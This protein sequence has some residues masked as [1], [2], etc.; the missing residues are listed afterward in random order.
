M[1][2]NLD[3]LFISSNMILSTENAA[4]APN[5]VQ[6]LVPFKERERIDAYKSPKG[7]FGVLFN[8][9][10]TWKQKNNTLK[11]LVT[12]AK[13]FDQAEV[14]P[15][16]L[17]TAGS[18]ELQ[19]YLDRS[20]SV[21]GSFVN[22]DPTQ[23][24]MGGTLMNQGVDAATLAS[25]AAGA[26]T[27]A[28]EAK[29]FCNLLP[30]NFFWKMDE[31]LKATHVKAAM[32]HAE[33]IAAMTL[34]VTAKATPI[35][36][37]FVFADDTM[38][39]LTFIDPLDDHNFVESYTKFIQNIFQKLLK[40]LARIQ[41]NKTDQN[42][43]EE[44]KK[45]FKQ[46]VEQTFGLLEH[47]DFSVFNVSGEVTLNAIMKL[48]ANELS[49][50]NFFRDYYQSGDIN[51]LL[52]KIQQKQVNLFLNK[53]QALQQYVEGLNEPEEFSTEQFAF[54]QLFFEQNFYLSSSHATKMMRIMSECEE[55]IKKFQKMATGFATAKLFPNTSAVSLFQK[56]MM[57]VLIC[58]SEEKIVESL[59][60]CFEGKSPSLK[61][62]YN[63]LPL[64]S[65]ALMY[66]I[67]KG[68]GW[69]DLKA[70][71]VL[72]QEVLDQLKTLITL[73]CSGG[74]T[75]TQIHYVLNLLKLVCPN[76]TWQ[77]YNNLVSQISN[78]RFRFKKENDGNSYMEEDYVAVLLQ[79][80]IDEIEDLF[81]M[82]T[83]L[84]QSQ[85]KKN[86]K[87]P[88]VDTLKSEL[89]KLKTTVDTISA[90]KTVESKDEK[91]D[92]KGWSTTKWGVVI[93]VILFG[94]ALGG[95]AIWFLMNPKSQEP[96]VE[97][98]PNLTT[99]GA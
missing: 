85:E 50:K 14:G 31:V 30:N 3:M 71:N 26:I 42:D 11:A 78:E 63:A 41:K 74:G 72:K 27:V 22:S 43:D 40:D 80:E 96:G 5:K 53:S 9:I 93:G 39:D 45:M 7:C 65:Q 75:L 76:K 77:E 99:A 58:E 23:M 16:K 97:V 98:D 12:C 60:A 24:K 73:I 21:C 56:R 10:N 84:K 57:K 25:G 70:E 48:Y 62:L 6:T 8:Q 88:Q 82:A 92:E 15:T 38:I 36:I 1:L 64:F 20:H 51:A 87:N 32:G 59:K 61:S 67:V 4:P 18:L 17:P 34:T 68:E 52:S 54:V 66:D 91:K 47:L 28:P 35:T 95:G 19:L 83:T 46:N 55:I 13:A 44:F 69:E 49:F 29:E 37:T 79:L 33:C 86:E 90:D 2:M 94:L 89:E 81:R